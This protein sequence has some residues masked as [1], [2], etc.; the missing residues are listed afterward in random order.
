MI[1]VI[2]TATVEQ[3]VTTIPVGAIHESPAMTNNLT[4]TIGRSKPLP[5]LEL[6]I[7]RLW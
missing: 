4:E 1:W 3:M 2:F 5:Y 6:I 7:S